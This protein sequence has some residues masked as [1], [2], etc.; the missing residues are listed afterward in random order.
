MTSLSKPTVY[1]KIEQ[2]SYA[3]ELERRGEEAK[4]MAAAK[5]TD[6]LK[7]VLKDMPV[8][9][10]N[11]N[12]QEAKG[13]EGERLMREARDAARAAV[14]STVCAIGSS[15]MEAAV[16]GLSSDENDTLMKFLYI[17]FAARTIRD[18]K[19]A[20]TY[21]CGILLK[22]HESICKC[23]GNGAV[24]RAIHTQLEA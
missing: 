10:K 7:L 6:A 22:A 8:R 17:G 1:L 9:K 16:K 2:M 23:A 24:I 11:A 14:C 21:D 18:G 3:S 15:K 19:E 13:A 4:G 20:C 5:G 12:P